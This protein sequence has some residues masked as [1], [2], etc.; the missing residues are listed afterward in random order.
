[1][2]GLHQRRVGLLESATSLEAELGPIPPEAILLAAL[3]AQ[4]EVP[5]RATFERARPK[6]AFIA[7]RGEASPGAVR[8]LLAHR[9]ADFWESSGGRKWGE[10]SGV[11]FREAAPALLSLLLE[12][13]AETISPGEGEPITL[14]ID[15]HGPNP[16]QHHIVYR[17][18]TVVTARKH[19]D[20]PV[21]DSLSR[22]IVLLSA[23]Q[24]CD[25]FCTFG[26]SEV[27]KTVVTVDGRIDNTEKGG[28][29]VG[30]TREDGLRMVLSPTLATLP[31]TTRMAIIAHEYGHAADFLYPG[32]WLQDGHGVPDLERWRA[33]ETNEIEL[34]ADQI[35]EAATGIAI[36]YG[37]RRL[38]QSFA[39][40]VRPRP[41]NLGPFGPGTLKR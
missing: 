13:G 22:N 29:T 24:V 18:W 20:N 21:T 37:G 32:C 41:K 33:R 6:R 27:Q 2:I 7:L 40:G 19:R 34:A 12:R 3:E 39:C 25:V 28:R 26:L 16:P 38:L 36:G 17:A 8:A 31:A 5:V 1:V 23:K 4:I 30:S 9:P 35:A 15:D 10:A 11:F 14:S